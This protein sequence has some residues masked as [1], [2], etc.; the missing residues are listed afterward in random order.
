MS[1]T[2]PLTLT[3]T[4]LHY[5]FAAMQNHGGG[6]VSRLAAAWFAADRSN[7]AR[8][9]GAFPHLLESF[10][11]GSPFYTPAQAGDNQ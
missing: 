5:T 9:E 4:E 6:F 10:G 7:R 3:P 1:P 2:T 11:P 8:I